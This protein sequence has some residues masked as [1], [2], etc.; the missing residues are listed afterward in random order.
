MIRIIS[1]L[2]LLQFCLTSI[3]GQDT[4]QNTS[5]NDSTK[6]NPLIGK[7]TGQISGGDGQKF[8]D[9]TVSI[10]NIN[11]RER[12][13]TTSN[14]NGSFTFSDLPVGVYQIG[15]FTSAYV[16]SFPAK[17]NNFRIGDSVS[18]L[19]VKGGVITGKILDSAGRPIVSTAVSALRV[20]DEDGRPTNPGQYG[21]EYTD[22]QGV[23][24][25]FGLREG[26]YIISAA[27]I[28]GNFFVKHNEIATYFPS[29]TRDTAQEIV[30]QP[31]AEITGIDVI[32]RNDRGHTVSGIAM[33]KSAYSNDMSGNARLNSAAT[34]ATIA[35]TFINA[36]ISTFS[37]Y[38]IPDG[39]YEVSALQ[40][41][42][43]NNPSQQQ[44]I[45][46]PIKIKVKGTDVSGVV[47]NFIA[48]G[49]IQGKLMLEKPATPNPSCKISRQ[50]YLEETVIRATNEDS[51]LRTPTF[52]QPT[53]NVGG[54]LSITQMPPGMY[55]L[56][57]DFPNDLWYLKSITLPSKT[58]KLDVARQGIYVKAGEKLTGLSMV[59]VE[60]AACLQGKIIAPPAQKIPSRNRVYLIPAEAS[61][62]ENL[63]RYFD[64]VSRDTSFSFN[65]IAP[66]KYWLYT[67]S[68]SE[69]EIVTFR[70]PNIWD[71][72]LRAQLRREAAAA[73]QLIDLA[74]CQKVKDFALNFVS[75]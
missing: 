59:M 35:S 39:E 61:E 66:G 13:V 19:M 64:V 70:N 18:I 7:I 55:R 62:A 63:T 29:S 54:G 33:I 20:R 60:G 43:S 36:S 16:S 17:M 44:A 46:S 47:L 71:A 22:D 48:A 28:E 69:T 53:L 2:L 73:K 41:F 67:T 52:F 11:T 32:H 49:S 15:A 57:A 40:F 50:S 9:V 42:N 8:S 34:G 75:K 3:F 12:R 27:P 4:K 26:T 68:I 38:G 25:I 37:F 24:R 10:Y 23:Y 72:K 45:A 1:A 14:E 21:N 65:N 58:L 56:S 51:E 5:T 6:T 30:V 74:P 31:G